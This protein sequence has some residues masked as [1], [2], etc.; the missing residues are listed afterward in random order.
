M[1]TNNIN[2][3]HKDVTLTPKNFYEQ[4]QDQDKL[5]KIMCTLAVQE[6]LIGGL[7]MALPQELRASLISSLEPMVLANQYGADELNGKYIKNLTK[8]WIDYI[9]NLLDDA[10]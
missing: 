7:I 8:I 1:Y 5:D 4:L 6:A 9:K 10:S 3:N 2:S